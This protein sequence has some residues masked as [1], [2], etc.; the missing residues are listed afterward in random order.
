[1]NLDE[2]DSQQFL[3]RPNVLTSIRDFLLEFRS[4]LFVHEFAP[5]RII[6]LPRLYRQKL[7]IKPKKDF[8]SDWIVVAVE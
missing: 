6:V 3:N 7:E 8:T 1:M 2:L 5:S 4:I